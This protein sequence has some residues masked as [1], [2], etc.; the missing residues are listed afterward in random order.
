MKLSV[1]NLLTG[2]VKDIKQGGLMTEVTVTLDDGREVV[3]VITANSVQRMQLK[4]G[5]P[6][7]VGIKSTE[8]MLAVD[9]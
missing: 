3:S 6:M 7:M 8:V 4:V 1:H 9:D 5:K 2:T